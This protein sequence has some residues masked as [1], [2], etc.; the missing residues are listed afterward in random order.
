MWKQIRLGFKQSTG[1][2]LYEIIKP[3]MRCPKLLRTST[4]QIT[5]WRCPTH[6]Q[7]S[8]NAVLVSLAI[9]FPQNL[10]LA[11]AFFLKTL[12]YLFLW[13]IIAFLFSFLKIDNNPTF[14]T[15]PSAAR[16]HPNDFCLINYPARNH[17]KVLSYSKNC[18][19]FIMKPQQ[20]VVV[21][22]SSGNIVV[23]QRKTSR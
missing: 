11:F 14:L 10:L 3:N 2:Q 8:H 15:C 6:L 12:Y 1:S 23:R 19:Y 16:N 17:E 5:N 7:H 4:H 13:I 9:V 22:S 21:A 20:N 18:F